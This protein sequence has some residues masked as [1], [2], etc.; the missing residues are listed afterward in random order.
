LPSCDIIF[1]G[2]DENH[3]KSHSGEMPSSQ[4]AEVFAGFIFWVLIL[5]LWKWFLPHWRIILPPS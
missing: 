1:F 3:Q 2:E 4:T 5:Y